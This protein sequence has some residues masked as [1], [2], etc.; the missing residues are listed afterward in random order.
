[1]PLAYSCFSLLLTYV[2]QQ[3]SYPGTK[4]VTSVGTDPTG[5][6]STTP[7]SMIFPRSNYLNWL[8]TVCCQSTR[9]Y[10]S[11]CSFHEIRRL[12]PRCFICTLWGICVHDVSTNFRTAPECCCARV[13]AKLIAKERILSEQMIMIRLQAIVR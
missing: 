10:Y 6:G 8:L 11:I 3:L 1:M 7:V 12:I 13:A 4:P 2:T 5:R 9:T